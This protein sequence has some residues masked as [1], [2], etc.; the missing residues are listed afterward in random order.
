MHEQTYDGEWWCPET[1]NRR[2]G[3]R[4]MYTPQNGPRLTL[5][6]RLLDDRDRQRQ[7]GHLPVIL[8]NISSMVFGNDITL[9]A[10][11]WDGDRLHGEYR[12][13]HFRCDFA[14][15]GAHLP[16]LAATVVTGCE[17]SFTNLDSWIDVSGF[18]VDGDADQR[19]HV[20]YDRP[21]LPELETS[22]G[23]ITLTL[24]SPFPFVTHRAVDVRESSRVTIRA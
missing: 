5:V 17:V 22:V 10:C 18:V 8:G 16:A 24:A 2:V 7:R 4:F 14:L 21:M 20:R 3:G 1:P 13:Q 12:E 15:L 23:T 11:R 9:L 6:G 19:Y